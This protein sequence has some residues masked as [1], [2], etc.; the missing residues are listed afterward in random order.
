MLPDVKV[1]LS[2]A[3]FEKQHIAGDLVLMRGLEYGVLTI[4]SVRVDGGITTRGI[5]RISELIVTKSLVR[6]AL[7]LGPCPIDKV[8]ISDGRFGALT[9]AQLEGHDVSLTNNANIRLIQMNS[10]KCDNVSMRNVIAGEVLMKECDL[11]RLDIHGTQ[12]ID[13]ATIEYSKIDSVEMSD[14]TLV[15][16]SAFCCDSNSTI[17]SMIMRNVVANIPI[18]I[19]S[20]FRAGFL[21]ENVVCSRIV[22]LRG[23]RT[24]RLLVLQN[25]DFRDTIYLSNQFIR[26]GIDLSEVMA[27][28]VVIDVY[29]YRAPEAV[30]KLPWSWIRDKRAVIIPLDSSAQTFKTIEA[31]AAFWL[32]KARSE[33]DE[34]TVNLIQSYVGQW[35][36]EMVSDGWTQLEIIGR[37]D[38]QWFVVISFLLLVLTSYIFYIHPASFGGA[39]NDEMSE[40]IDKKSDL[41]AAI[42]LAVQVFVSIRYQLKLTRSGYTSVTATSLVCWFTGKCVIFVVIL[43]YLREYDLV[44][45]LSQLSSIL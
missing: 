36:R 13:G 40:R 35:R 44:G 12:L 26:R 1:D 21:M 38:Y 9:I 28:Y 25:C 4:D 6:D 43:V 30:I 29:P 17:T 22:D 7:K 32:H 3:V 42:V 15:G 5:P 14:D 18:S 24:H 11:A 39:P 34:Q 33:N 45:L 23:I 27:E 2:Q 37:E 16:K 31:M 19:Q 10:I 8:S 20:V 41:I